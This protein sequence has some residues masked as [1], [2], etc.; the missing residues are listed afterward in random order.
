MPFCDGKILSTLMRENLNFL[1]RHRGAVAKR[2]I[3][4]GKN[5]VAKWLFETTNM[6]SLKILF[7]TVKNTVAKGLL[8]QLIN[9]ANIFG[10]G[11]AT[12]TKNLF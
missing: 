12:V 10:D 4:D 9:N 5:T 7:S 2:V 6:S 3:C 1:R 8:F 11:Y